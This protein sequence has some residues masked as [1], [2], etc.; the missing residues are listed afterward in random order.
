MIKCEP[1][2]ETKLEE[3]CRSSSWRQKLSLVEIEISREERP[4]PPKKVKNSIREG[5]GGERNK[6]S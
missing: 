3:E 1:R 6:K 5:G 4:P 2:R